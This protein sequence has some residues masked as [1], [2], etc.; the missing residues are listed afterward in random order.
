MLTVSPTPT[1]SRPGIFDFAGRAKWD[2]WSAAGKSYANQLEEAE[3]RY[4]DIARELG[5]KEGDGEE[6]KAKKAQTSQPEGDDDDIWDK[7][8]APKKSG[9]SGGMG[10]VVSTMAA[11]EETEQEKETLH[12]LARIGNV[13]GFKEFLASHPGT[14]VN[15]KDENVSKRKTCTSDLVS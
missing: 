4:L 15:A 3:R 5:W 6:A 14:D 1:T 11:V 10:N 13:E 2:A 12:S 7:D 9:G 8:D